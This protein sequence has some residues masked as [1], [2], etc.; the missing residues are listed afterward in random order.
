MNIFEIAMGIDKLVIIK[1][2]SPNL[3]VLPYQKGKYLVSK[4]G[5]FFTL[6]FF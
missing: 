4:R 2:Y 5:H 3:K 6:A 1:K